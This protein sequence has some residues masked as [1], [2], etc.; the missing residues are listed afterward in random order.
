[1][2]K[3][4]FL[5]DPAHSG[6]FRAETDPLAMLAFDPITL[7]LEPVR[8]AWDEANHVDDADCEY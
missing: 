8:L 6:L 2:G 4:K 3:A 5:A 1:M 7:A